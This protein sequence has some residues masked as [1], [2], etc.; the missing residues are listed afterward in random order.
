MINGC[1][2]V[3]ASSSS[4][5]KWVQNA[6]SRCA[7]SAGFA[8]ISTSL[9]RRSLSLS[10]QSSSSSLPSRR[11][12]LPYL[13][14][15]PS[16]HRRTNLP[17]TNISLQFFSS[18]NSQEQPQPS[19]LLDPKAPLRPLLS[20]NSHENHL[21]QYTLPPTE[22]GIDDYQ[23]NLKKGQRIVSFGD[24]HGDIDAL[25]E[26]LITAELLDPES[27]NDE[28]MWSGGETI[29]VQT[30]DVLDRG[31]DELACFRLLATLARQA[32][33]A[34]GALLLLY[35]NHESLNA[36]GL[37]QYANP[38]GNTEFERTI[39]QRID[40]NYG[41]NRWRLQFAGNEPSRWASFEPGGL[42]AENMLGNMLV[43]CVIGRTV[44][45]HAGL[46]ASHLRG[47]NEENEN[48]EKRFGGVSKLNEQ[49]REWILKA[50]HGDNN[51]WG[52]FNTVEEVIRA[53]Q[54]RA[55]VASKTMPD[56]LGGGIGAS[57]PV[58]M[59][60]YSQPNDKEPKNP[61]AGNMIVEA[62]AESGPNMQRMVMGHTPQRQINSALGGKAWRIDVGASRGV[63]GGTPE[64]LEIVH[65]GGENDEDVINILTVDGKR[66]PGTNRSVTDDIVMDFFD[67]RR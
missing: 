27:T 34:G 1:S 54:N 10:P 20:E 24:V 33:Q 42:L 8:T 58:W 39:G 63:M 37:F 13:V 12:N 47:G 5:R 49:A 7:S 41:S 3:V 4:S 26:F 51:N 48:G 40:Y 60:D 55:K 6:A 23:P 56:C 25:R 45:V 35:G 28:P 64:V 19:L 36:A 29:C 21:S 61:K 9:D 2:V 59:R 65:M 38:G 44:F 32:K 11:T 43:A 14:P 62:L 22:I 18:K 67:I 16:F 31:D 46:Q 57:S 52:E 30:G 53:A 17:R 15:S 50:H 66:I